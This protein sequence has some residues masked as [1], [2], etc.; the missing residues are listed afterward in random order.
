MDSVRSGSNREVEIKL[1]LT[2]SAEGRRRLKRAGFGIAKRRAFEQNTLF[3]NGAQDL[4]QTG[5]LL[6]LRTCGPRHIL[7]LKGPAE[8]GR[9]KTREELEVDVS[10]RATFEEILTRLGY[11]P[12]YRYEKYR[13]E[14]RQPDSGGSAMLDETP[15]GVF[16]ELEG[17]PEW[18]DRTAGTLGFAEA[19]YITLSYAELHRRVTGGETGDMVFGS[20]RRLQG[21]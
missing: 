2:D 10:D 6:R 1:F 4:R 5:I 12:V 15:V 7:T 8:P 11:R 14:Y 21:R 13:S 16:L 19:D 18:I 17:P 20:P 3:D 9:H